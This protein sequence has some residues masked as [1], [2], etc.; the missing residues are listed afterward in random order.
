MVLGKIL[1][2][3][4]SAPAPLNIDS[5]LFPEVLYVTYHEASDRYGCY[6][7]EGVHG[8]AC[9]SNEELAWRWIERS[10]FTEVSV[11]KRSFDEV[12]DIARARP[13]PVTAI[14]LLDRMDNPK[15]HYIR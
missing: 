5:D 14:L 12:W 10:K 15:I 3:S 11:L 2:R 4:T 13:S 9:F 6:R 7:Y 8:L 1:G